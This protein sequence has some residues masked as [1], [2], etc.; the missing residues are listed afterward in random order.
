MKTS[1]SLLEQV[2]SAVLIA[3]ILGLGWIMLAAVQPGWLRLPSVELEVLLVLGL[4]TAA[5]L[6]VSVVALQQTR[7]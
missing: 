6:L 1:L 4:L 2:A 7:G 5:L 3:V